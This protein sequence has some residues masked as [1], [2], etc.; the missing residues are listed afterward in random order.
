MDISNDCPDNTPEDC[1]EIDF[2]QTEWFD[3]RTPLDEV[4]SHHGVCV[5]ADPKHP[6]RGFPS[7]FRFNAEE[8]RCQLAD[9]FRNPNCKNGFT[10]YALNETHG[11]CKCAYGI[12]S[13]DGKCYRTYSQ[14]IPNSFF[15]KSHLH[16]FIVLKGPCDK[17]HWMVEGN[18]GEVTCQPVKCKIEGNQLDW[19]MEKSITCNPNDDEMT[20]KF[21]TT[22]RFAFDCSFA[23]PDVSARMDDNNVQCDGEADAPISCYREPHTSNSFFLLCPLI[24]N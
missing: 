24:L 15:F 7:G 19:P 21:E 18:E 13:V 23:A 12:W 3:R 14:V 1:E 16:N 10:F 2:N 17:D 9:D 22:L 4:K 8:N 20:A 5:W 11:H 6:C